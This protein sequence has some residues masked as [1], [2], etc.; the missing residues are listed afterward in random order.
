MILELDMHI[1]ES[2]KEVPSTV[3]SSNAYNK[4]HREIPLGHLSLDAH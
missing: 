1:E 2:L 3:Q 4:P